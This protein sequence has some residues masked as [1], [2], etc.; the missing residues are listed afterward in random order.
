VGK[1]A[2]EFLQQPSVL[3]HHIIPGS[4]V[5]QDAA[6]AKG[7]YGLSEVT[8]EFIAGFRCQLL[9]G[10]RFIAQCFDYVLLCGC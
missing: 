3:W 5:T 2:A 9:N 7:S 1:S 6:F 4:V 10:E 8:A